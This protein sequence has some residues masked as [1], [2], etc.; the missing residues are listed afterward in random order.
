MRNS[1]NALYYVYTIVD[2]KHN[3][4]SSDYTIVSDPTTEEISMFT[5]ACHA[6][7]FITQ[8]NPKNSFEVLKVQLSLVKTFNYFA[9]RGTLVKNLN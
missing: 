9:E 2:D 7:D 3:F 1:K 4:I 5:R 8:Y 6:K